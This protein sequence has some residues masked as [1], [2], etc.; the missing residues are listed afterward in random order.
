MQKNSE[1]REVIFIRLL[2]PNN[3]DDLSTLVGSGTIVGG[4]KLGV[5]GVTSPKQLEVLR[6][7]GVPFEE[8]GGGTP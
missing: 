6:R 8:V 2:R 5:F 3:S 4:P 1:P 7:E